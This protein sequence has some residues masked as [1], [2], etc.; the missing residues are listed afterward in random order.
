MVFRNPDGAA[1]AYEAGN[2]KRPELLATL[3]RALEPARSVSAE[4][5]CAAVDGLRANGS[6]SA[7]RIMPLG[8]KNRA[9]EVRIKAAMWLGARG[10]R[11]AIPAL[12]EGAAKQDVFAIQ[13]L[14]RSHDVS[15]IP[16]LKRS[17]RSWK[18]TGR[19]MPTLMQWRRR[20]CI[21]ALARLHDPWGLSIT[22]S[23][24][25]GQDWESRSSAAS[26]LGDSRDVHSIPLL[27]RALR[28]QRMAVRLRAVEA[29]GKLQ[30][31]KAIPAIDRM[32]AEHSP[33]H[34]QGPSGDM[35]GR[36]YA[37]YVAGC[38]RKRTKPETVTQFHM[39]HRNRQP[40]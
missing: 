5:A 13:L 25:A 9:Y 10:D 30:A 20:E 24:L 7:W 23:W 22:R 16:V 33:D 32:V 38:L 2:R 28:D 1:A 19:E 31:V 34:L 4:V 35:D 12:L 29:L 14:G 37:A 11:K 18:E 36:S 21:F 26:A 3:R 8:L 17:Y 40:H 27:A 39:S 15:A 6:V